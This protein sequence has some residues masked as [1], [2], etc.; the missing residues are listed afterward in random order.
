V[1]SDLVRQDMELADHLLHTLGDFNQLEGA[2]R[3]S[4]GIAGLYDDY[5]NAAL[6]NKSRKY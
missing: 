4:A 5:N 1:N 6:C 2:S 3:F